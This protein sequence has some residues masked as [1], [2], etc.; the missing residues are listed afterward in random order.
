[1]KGDKGNPGLVGLTGAP[2][3][4]G[5]KGDPGMKG[6][7]SVSDLWLLRRVPIAWGL[8]VSRTRS[9]EV[10]WLLPGQVMGWDC[11]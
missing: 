5:Q 2:G 1:M 10:C 3:L 4:K 11:P 7:A 6:K 8:E 9:V